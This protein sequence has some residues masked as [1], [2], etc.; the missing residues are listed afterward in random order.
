MRAIYDGHT[1]VYTFLLQKCFAVPVFFDCS[2]DTSIADIFIACLVR[3][4]CAAASHSASSKPLNAMSSPDANVYKPLR[5]VNLFRCIVLCVIAVAGNRAPYFSFATQSNQMNHNFCAFEER[6]WWATSNG[7][8]HG[9]SNAKPQRNPRQWDS[10]AAN[11][12]I[13][14][15]MTPIPQH[16]SNSTGSPPPDRVCV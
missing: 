1:N 15:T 10:R 12:L 5:L 4:V 9:F 8:L 13:T 3:F 16:C 6:R 2:R 11:A 7:C 14:I